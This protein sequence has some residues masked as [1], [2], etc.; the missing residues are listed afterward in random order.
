L[1][2]KCKCTLVK[3]LRNIKMVCSKVYISQ[4]RQIVC[5][6]ELVTD[7]TAKRKCTVVRLFRG[8]KTACSKIDRT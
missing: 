7:L 2:V 6:P 4:V 8:I 3:L 1:T 5:L